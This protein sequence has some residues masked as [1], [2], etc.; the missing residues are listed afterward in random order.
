MNTDTT[1]TVETSVPKHIAIIMDGNGR[2][3]SKQNLPHIDGHRAGTEAARNTIEACGERG[4]QFLTL[5][6]FSSENWNRPPEE[7]AALMALIVEMLPAEHDLMMKRGVRFRMIG[8]REG[9]PHEV[10]QVIGDAENQ[11]AQNTGLQLNIALNYGARQEIVHAA[12]RLA[13][14]VED[15]KTRPEEIDEAQFSNA[16]WTAELPDPDLLIRTSGELRL[17]NFLL[18]QLSYAEIVITDCL[19]PEFNEGELDDAITAYAQRQ[20]R[21]GARP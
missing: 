8:D 17:S 20:R 19:W 18:W 10:Q 2:W 14:D 4:V 9:L 7:V 6:S 15:G 11:T 16:L 12:K 21:Y 13:K 3:A 1:D 5:Y